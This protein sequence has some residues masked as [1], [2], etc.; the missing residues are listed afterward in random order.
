MTKK[1]LLYIILAISIGSLLVSTCQRNRPASP[2]EVELIKTL[3]WKDEMHKTIQRLQDNNT[4]LETRA[5]ILED[6]NDSLSSRINKLM[7]A[8]I[9][10]GKRLARNSTAIRNKAIPAEPLE[11]SY[12]PVCDPLPVKDILLSSPN[13]SVPVYRPEIEGPSSERLIL[14][15]DVGDISYENDSVAFFISD[16]LLRRHGI[17][18]V[19]QLEKNNA[20]RFIKEGDYWVLRT[21]IIQS[22][23]KEK[24]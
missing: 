4:S 7:R 21:R 20:A 3:E 12:T 22:M 6:R 2:A 10:L 13:G 23:D 1:N 14:R 5:S 8:S 24:N 11:K 17:V 18:G 15:D 9:S 16:N 19:P